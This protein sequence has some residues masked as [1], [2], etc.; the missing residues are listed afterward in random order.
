MSNCRCD[1]EVFPKPLAIPP[2]VED[3]A[4]QI[5]M[6]PE[7]REGLLDQI[8]QFPALASWRARDNSDYGLMLLEMWALLADSVSFYDQVIA[9]ELYLRPSR[10]RPSLRKLTGLLGYVPR[11]ASSASA[12]L[13]ALASGKQLVVVPSGSGF[14]SGAFSGNPP[15]VFETEA[16]STIHPAFNEWTLQTVRPATFPSGS[17]NDKFLLAQQGTVTAKKDDTV[18]LVAGSHRRALRVVSVAAYTGVDGAVYSKIEF[19]SNTGIAAGTLVSATR[20]LKPQSAS[21]VWQQT[22]AKAITTT[23]NPKRIKL[24]G[25]NRQIRP[26]N[27]VFVGRE[28][29][30]RWFRVTTTRDVPITV[31]ESTTTNITN[32][33]NTI[34]NKVVSPAVTA[35]TTRIRTDVNVTNANRGVA[36]QAYVWSIDD[37]DIQVH[38]GMTD[39]ATVTIEASPDLASTDPLKIVGRASLPAGVSAPGRF[40]L[41]DTDGRGEEVMGTLNFSTGEL[42]LAQGSAWSPAL[43]APVT[44]YGNVL[45]ASRGEL[46]SGEVLGSGD[47]TQRHQT[48]TL[49]QNPLSYTASPTAGNLKGVAAALSFYVDGVQWSE[50]PSFF[51]IA[52]DANVY[53]L[54]QD[55]QGKTQ[56]TTNRLRTGATV[57]AYYRHGAGAAAPPAG[58]ILQLAKPVENLRGVRQPIA[59]GGGSDAESADQLRTLAPRSALLLGRCVSILDLEAAASIQPGVRAA[60]AEWRWNKTRQRAVAQIFYIG[61][62]GIEADIKQA[63]QGLT[64]PTTP[65]EATR[66]EARLDGLSIDIAID[67]RYLEADVLANVRAVLLEPGK[68]MLTP[69]K[70]GIG[71]PLFRSAIFERVLSVR[72]TLA[73]RGLFIGDFGWWNHGLKPGAGKYFDFE[74]GGLS[75]NGR[76]Q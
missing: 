13:A 48:F 68:G 58:S 3:L 56:I 53:T 14:R 49:K 15:Q 11:P 1:E 57:S 55:D 46:V 64:D 43:K 37:V 69:E 39:A 61:D 7:Y 36:G 25:I 8:R 6:F 20:L 47:S 26:G 73:V 51:G 76:E 60:S 23:F 12:A 35:P 24:D 31:V 45:D 62:E 22:D 30:L 27:Y 21:G 32:A 75:L 34:V 9:H 2:G 10:L 41:A 16:A 50:T 66:A 44:L 5:A 65:I 63:L 59:A 4:R 38:W 54:R 74:Q 67:Q 17:G 29:D 40:L 42:Q 33:S 70:L 19:T 72:G 28:N 71:K 52:E 18:L